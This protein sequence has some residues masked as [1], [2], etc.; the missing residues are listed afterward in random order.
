[1]ELLRTTSHKTVEIAQQ[2]GLGEASY[3]SYAFKKHF[4]VS[5]SQVR[6]ENE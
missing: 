2:C 4:G 3:F 6:K 1:M 5:P